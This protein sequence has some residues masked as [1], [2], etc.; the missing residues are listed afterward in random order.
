MRSMTWISAAALAVVML[1]GAGCASDASLTAGDVSVARP[2]PGPQVSPAMSIR[3]VVQVQRH[4]YD[5]NHRLVG[6]PVTVAFF[7]FDET[8]GGHQAWISAEPLPILPR[9]L[10]DGQSSEV[11][12]VMDGNHACDSLTELKGHVR[13]V[14]SPWFLA[15]TL[16]LETCEFYC[17]WPSVPWSGGQ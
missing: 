3:G 10:A 1:L 14:H 15:Q 2:K 7:E 17:S 9:P 8:N 4:T 5:Q 12:F 11:V 13:S 6:P 16:P